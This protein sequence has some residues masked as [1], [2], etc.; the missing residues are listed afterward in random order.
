[1]LVAAILPHT[2]DESRSLT[3]RIPLV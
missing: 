1:V 2:G 3:V